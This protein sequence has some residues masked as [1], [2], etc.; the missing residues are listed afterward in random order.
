[1]K[2]G[3]FDKHL[4]FG[5]LPSLGIFIHSASNYPGQWEPVGLNHIVLRNDPD[6][7]GCFLEDCIDRQRECLLS[8][9][10][11]SVYKAVIKSLHTINGRYSENFT[12][13]P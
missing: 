1:M 13:N 9:D 4:K 6:C 5:S 12:C 8:I 3:E 7:A 10:V 2:I 11:D